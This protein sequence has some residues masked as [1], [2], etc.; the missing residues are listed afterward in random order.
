MKIPDK[1]R[2]IYSTHALRERFQETLGV[3][4]VVP[5]NFIKIGCKSIEEDPYG[6]SDIFRARYIF[7]DNRD[8]ILVINKETGDVTTNFLKRANN[9]G[10]FKGR[11][12]VSSIIRK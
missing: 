6:N 7:D 2:L 11:Y 8:L 10:I 1:L 5:T 9:K 12:S 4:D 3:I